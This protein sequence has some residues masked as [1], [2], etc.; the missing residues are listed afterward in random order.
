MINDESCRIK[1]KEMHTF[2][3]VPHL[4]AHFSTR[5]AFVQVFTIL[6]I[7][8]LGLKKIGYCALLEN[9]SY[10]HRHRS[11]PAAYRLCGIP[12]RK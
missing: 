2:S 11:L 10:L 9:A 7:V 12:A 6:E 4:T 1:E 5:L 8:P 3:N